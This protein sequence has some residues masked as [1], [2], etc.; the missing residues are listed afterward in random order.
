MEGRYERSYSVRLMRPFLAV[1]KGSDR[2]PAG[3]LAPLEGLDPDQRI[4][5]ESVHTMLAN[6]VEFTADADLGLK[7][8]REFARG[9]SGAVDYAISSSAT[10]RDALAVAAR[11]VRL[12]N[13]ALELVL[14][15]APGEMHLR[16]ESA[17][18]LPRAAADFETGAFYRV[19][20]SAWM[21]SARAELRV[22]LAY[23]EPPDRREYA[24][25]FDGAKVEFGAKFTGFAFDARVLDVPLATADERLHQVIRKHVELT[26]AE[27]PRAETLTERVRG[28][29]ARELPSGAVSVVR[30]AKVVGMSPRTLERKLAAEGATFSAVVEE[31]R[32]SLAF[33]YIREGTLDLAEVALLLGFSQTSAFHRAFKRWTGDTP[34]AYRRA[35]A[36]GRGRLLA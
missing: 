34:L 27:L 5:I 36:A 29:V 8:A 33:R 17:V 9:D 24:L 19:H 1:L 10:V 32:K 2:F 31:L 20:T 3:L 16:F 35:H 15:A 12:V 14:E 6:A 25:T 18:P 4:A 22:M 28:V 11:Y 7:A 21:S 13:D 30:V 26:V 23:P